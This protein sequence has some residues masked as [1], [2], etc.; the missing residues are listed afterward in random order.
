[1]LWDLG[2]LGA[3][4]TVWHV[5][6]LSLSLDLHI[7]FFSSFFFVLVCFLPSS[8]P[9]ASSTSSP[10][11]VSRRRHR[12]SE[13]CCLWSQSHGR[14]CLISGRFA[15]MCFKPSSQRQKNKVSWKT[16]CRLSVSEVKKTFNSPLRLKMSL[17][18][19]WISPIRTHVRTSTHHGGHANISTSDLARFEQQ[20]AKFQT[21]PEEL[22]QC[23]A[24]T[25]AMVRENTVIPDLVP[26]PGK[27]PGCLKKAFHFTSE[28]DEFKT[29]T[30]FSHNPFL[31][32][33]AGCFETIFA[34]SR[35]QVSCTRVTRRRTFLI[36]ENIRP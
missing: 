34:L 28:T 4:H 2:S 35:F 21:E 8:L 1:M 20:L 16:F 6:S 14:E 11:P 9:P 12:Q 32:F 29:T 15:F 10:D 36:F 5:L 27:E 19:R 23:F 17:I 13:K 25:R 30:P 26:K 3:L 22:L 7:L 33:L 31:L 24:G 18:A